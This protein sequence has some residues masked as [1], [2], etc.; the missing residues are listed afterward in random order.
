MDVETAKHVELLFSSSNPKS[1]NS[2]FGVLNHCCTPGGVRALRSA[3]FQPP[4][5][6]E[7]SIQP[8]LDAV[9]EL[10]NKPE[11]LTGLQ[12]VLGR[13]PDLDRLLGLCVTV[14]KQPESLGSI[15]NKINNI[16]GLKVKRTF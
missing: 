15:E 6:V 3:L 1:N 16:I 5:K 8:R 14:P 11:L 7:E 4:V 9:D 13:F 10:V 12:A 2:L